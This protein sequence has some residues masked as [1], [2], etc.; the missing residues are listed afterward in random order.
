MVVKYTSESNKNYATGEMK[1]LFAICTGVCTG[2]T[3]GNGWKKIE[4]FALLR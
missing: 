1:K 4:T 3:K 2:E